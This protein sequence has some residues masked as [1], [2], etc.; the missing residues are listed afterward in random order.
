MASDSLVMNS[1]NLLT[2]ALKKIHRVFALRKGP[3]LW[4][5]FAG[6]ILVTGTI[7][8]GLYRFLEYVGRAP[9]L[10]ETFGPVIGGLLVGKLLEMLL[11]TLF[12]MVL[13]SSIISALSAFYLNEEL[14]VLMASPQPVG[15]I[16]RSRFILMTFESSWMVMAFFFPALIAFATALNA[17][18]TAY[19]IFILFL[20]FFI[21]LPN[22]F[23]ASFA[24]LLGSFFPIRQMRKIFQFLSIIVLTSLIFFLRSLEAEKLLNPSYFKDI[25]Q[26]ILSLQLPL[27]EFSPSSWLHQSALKLFNADYQGA[28]TS[29]LPLAGITLGGLL[30]LN[31]LAAL[32]YRKSWQKS[33]EAIENQVLSLEWIRKAI[34]FPLR[35]FDNVF[36]VIAT[37]EI[38]TF[39]RDPAIFSQIFMMAAIVFV[40][41]YNL[42]I[43]PLKDIPSLYSG[44]LN[45]TLVFLNGPFIGFILASIGMRFVYPS[46]SMEGRAFWAVKSSP[47]KPGR[48]LF[49]KFIVYLIPMLL[50]GIVLCAV[51]NSI[52]TVTSDILWWMSFI[53]VGLIS[54]VITALAISV[55]SIHADFAADSPLK[56]A[57]SY[58]GFIYMILSGLYIFNL[59]ALEAYPMY[60]F[61]F[62]RF[63]P[64]RHFSGEFTIIIC[65]I[66]LLICTYAW[67][68]IPFKKG[69][70]VIENYEPE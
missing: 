35:Y 14:P 37:K 23:G 15:R 63:I 53:N 3:V 11:L 32:L 27:L 38:T 48:I 21:I 4:L 56:I 47:V 39:L 31:M 61:F 10:G 19:F 60:R 7:Y 45:D 62:H 67:L 29:F 34:T 13:F 12:F 25:S 41:G 40:Y 59:I 55:G 36:R 66:L 30:V 64:T 33:M 5:L 17:N 8:Y 46:I 70:K 1:F 18:A 50:V 9:M 69:L 65:A 16:F 42:T 20:A 28:L 26:Y 52:F 58:G 51:T 2:P 68:T 57:G 6:S 43:L 24:L 49:I 54:I 22:I 44:E